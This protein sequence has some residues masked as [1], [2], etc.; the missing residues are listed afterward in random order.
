MV[1]T[2]T[3]VSQMAPGGV[4][5]RAA[6]ASATGAAR[7]VTR[8]AGSSPA[9]RATRSASRSPSGAVAFQAATRSWMAMAQSTALVGEAKSAS[10]ASPATSARRPSKACSAGTTSRSCASSRRARSSGGRA[11]ARSPQPSISAASS[12]SVRDLGS[13]ETTGQKRLETG[14]GPRRRGG[15]LPAT[16]WR[17]VLRPPSLPS[18]MESSS[19]ADWARPAGSFT[20]ARATKR[21]SA[22]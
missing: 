16:A 3:R 1:S 4:R 10:S 20:V 21:S 5:W 17:G 6:S 14:R 11:A 22:G 8:P 18:R 2:T 7:G 9:W 19:A 15:S 13:P 12:V